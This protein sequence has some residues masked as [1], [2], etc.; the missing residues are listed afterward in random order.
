[1]SVTFSQYLDTLF[2]KDPQAG[3]DYHELQVK[4]VYCYKR[5]YILII[6]WNPLSFSNL[7][8]TRIKS[9]FP[10]S[11]DHCNFIIDFSNYPIFWTSFRFTWKFEKSGFHCKLRTV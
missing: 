11:V 1:M 3:M 8:I 9:R 2:V 10:S 6:Q 4:P 5:D 7:Q